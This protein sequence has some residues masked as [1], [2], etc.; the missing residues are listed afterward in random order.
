MK[1]IHE[2]PFEEWPEKLQDATKGI[3]LGSEYLR[4]IEKRE[5]HFVEIYHAPILDDNSPSFVI[6]QV[7]VTDIFDK[8][9]YDEYLK[10]I[11]LKK[12]WMIPRG[13]A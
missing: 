6:T 2:I 12:C 11:A 5:G 4:C 1:T 3:K 10:K 7:I 8:K 13:F 9:E